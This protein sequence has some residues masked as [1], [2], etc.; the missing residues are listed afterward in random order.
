MSNTILVTGATGTVGKQ[1]L[2]ALA[3][4][5]GVNVLAAV[6]SA[7]KS[8][9]LRTSG[10]T[11]V[12]FDWNNPESIAAALS[13]VDRVFL[14]TPFQPDQVE[15]AKGLIDA[16]KAAGVKHIVKLSASGA[17]AEPGIQLGRWH[18]QVEKIL[19]ASGVPFTVVRPATF[20]ENFVNYYPPG[21]DGN[22]YLPLGNGAVSFIAARDIGEVS[23]KLLTDPVEEHAGRFYEI[24]GGEALTVEQVAAILSEKQG[25]AVKFVDVPEEAARKAM[26]DM[27][28]PSWAVDAMLELH[29]ISKAGYASGVT[30]GVQKILG[31]PPTRFADV[32]LGA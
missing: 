31:R 15:L 24:T 32:Q 11:P 6:R 29:A 19:E 5:A 21:P 4:K 20:M 17:D 7:A 27:Q 25:R 26:L 8:D 13:G 12:D 23:A 22:I 18:R 2:K 1:V 14:L 10:V 30:D 3:G 9:A 28:M 16:A